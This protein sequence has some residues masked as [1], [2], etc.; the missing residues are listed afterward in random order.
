MI[1]TYKSD[2][3]DQQLL[4]KVATPVSCRVKIFFYITRY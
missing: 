2:V 1:E 3:C 4:V